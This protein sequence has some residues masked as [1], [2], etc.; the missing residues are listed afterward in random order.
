M[1]KLQE[2]LMLFGW[3]GVGTEEVRGLCSVEIKVMIETV[4]RG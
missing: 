1:M 2:C 4:Q 3:C